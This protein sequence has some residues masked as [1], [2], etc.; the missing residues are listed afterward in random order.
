MQK[1]GVP[2]VYGTFVDL[3]VFV[4]SWFKSGRMRSP[5]RQGILEVTRRCLVSDQQLKDANEGGRRSEVGSRKSE[6]TTLTIDDR[7][8][9]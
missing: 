8:I 4:S 1:A 6:K 2:E 3:S 5:D 7:L 9:S